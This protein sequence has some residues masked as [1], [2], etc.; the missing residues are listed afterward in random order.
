MGLPGELE[1]RERRSKHTET[2]ISLNLAPARSTPPTADDNPDEAH[3]CTRGRLIRN[4]IIW[5]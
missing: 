1:D 2:G 4:A 3:R 5:D